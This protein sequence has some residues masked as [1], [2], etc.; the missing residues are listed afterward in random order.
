[1]E[2]THESSPVSPGGRLSQHVMRHVTGP[3]PRRAAPPLRASARSPRAAGRPAARIPGSNFIR[4][5]H[6]DHLRG[7]HR[8]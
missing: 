8:K 2:T 3:G 6:L 4:R 5:D 7:V 1:M